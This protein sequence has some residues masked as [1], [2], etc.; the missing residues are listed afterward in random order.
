MSKLERAVEEALRRKHELASESESATSVDPE[1][2]LAAII[3]PPPV[4]DE[5]AAQAVEV[6]FAPPLKR[7]TSSVPLHALLSKSNDFVA[8]EV[9]GKIKSRIL[10][11]SERAPELKRIM[12]TSTLKSEGKSLTAVN[13]AISFSRSYGQPVILVDTDLRAPTVHTYLETRSSPGLVQC[14]TGEASISEALVETGIENLKVLPAGGTVTNPVELLAS[15]QCRQLIEGLSQTNKKTFIFFD[16]P[17]V[18]PFADAHA[19]LPNMGGVIF[20]IREGFTRK[21]QFEEAIQNLDDASFVGILF[22]GATRN[23]KWKAKDG[24][25]YGYSY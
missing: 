23:T 21:D 18:L 12:I 7:E 17:P 10:R 19:L 3:Q 1:A 24:Y 5:E 15:P 13:L 16:A 6:S 11:L 8:A 2:E 4:A 9:Y 25:G 14:I 22:N 20:V